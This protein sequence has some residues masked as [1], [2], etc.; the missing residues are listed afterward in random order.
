MCTGPFGRGKMQKPFE[1]AAFALKMGEM[2]D[3]IDTESGVHIIL[4]T[5]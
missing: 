5:G 2:S 1:D 3:V 4:R